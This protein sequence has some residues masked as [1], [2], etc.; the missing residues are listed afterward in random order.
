MYIDWTYI[1]LVL[2]AVIFS[3]IASLKVN[4]TFKKYSTVMSQ[5]R[6]TGSDAVNAVLRHNGVSGITIDRVS[7]NLTDHFDPR[8]KSIH[9]SDGVYGSSSVAAIGVAAHEAGHA[10]QHAVGYAPIK[11]RSAIVSVTNVASSVGSILIPLGIVLCYAGSNAAWLAYLGVILYSSCL[12]F[13]LITL[14]T[15]FNASRRAMVALEETGTLN[16]TELKQAKK[17]L[18]AAAMTYVAALAVS[19]MTVFRFLIIIA[20][21]NKN[22]RD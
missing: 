20:G 8:D 12:L 10:V 4:S 3:L 13:Q 6:V 1:V 22:S 21:A 16:D 2:P 18:S 11:I 7:G 14:P 5:N 17:V 19:A 9:L 15:E